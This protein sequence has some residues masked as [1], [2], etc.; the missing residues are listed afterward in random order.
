MV[1]KTLLNGIDD[2]KVK[3]T[4]DS[5]KHKAELAKIMAADDMAAFIWDMKQ[6]LRGYS[7]HAIA[8]TPTEIYNEFVEN[9]NI[10]GIDLDELI[11]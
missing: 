10:R 5:E 2:M 4:L 3:I 7:K 9:M 1:P 11:A 8:K 6:I